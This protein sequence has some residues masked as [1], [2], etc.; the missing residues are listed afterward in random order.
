MSNT[1]VANSV[2]LERA[3]VLLRPGEGR[4]FLGVLVQKNVTE[5]QRAKI[6][7]IWADYPGLSMEN[8]KLTEKI[9][10]CGLRGVK[11][12]NVGWLLIDYLRKL[13]G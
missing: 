2:F 13:I 5:C 6:W 10:D 8:K 4:E 11:D 9:I 3:F 1:A 7:A 12:L